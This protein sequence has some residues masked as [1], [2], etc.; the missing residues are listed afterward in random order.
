MND[1]NTRFDFLS[2]RLHFI[3]VATDHLLNIELQHYLS[4]FENHVFGVFLQYNRIKTDLEFPR[5][6]NSHR[7]QIPQAGL[8]IYYY[9]LTW[10]KL[11][12]IY[13][14]I[15]KLINRLQKKVSRFPSQFAPEF[16]LWRC[17]I[18]H[19]FKEFDTEVRN[20]YEH[21]SLK[22]HS[23]G[24]VIM[25]G[26]I[27]SDNSGNIKAQVAEKFYSIVKKEHV[28][29]IKQL[30]TDLF[31]LFIKHFS[32]KPLT[33]ELI[34]VRDYI[35]ENIDSLLKELNNFN[36]K[37]NREDFN[38]LLSQIMMCQINLSQEGIQLSREVTRKIYTRL[39]PSH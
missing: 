35:E 3:E 5:P 23:V 15:K 13:I 18:D 28:E 38:N 10:D 24:N 30:R 2:S 27:F 34:K 17:R 22:F 16:R 26:N 20:Q 4:V 14:E 7:V 37:K 9:T 12:K 8:D 29:R 11:K 33:Q 6:E 39:F 21:P 32:E 1:D 31:D 36:E 25:W 19:L